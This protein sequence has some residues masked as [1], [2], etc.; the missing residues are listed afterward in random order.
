MSGFVLDASALIAFLTGEKG[1]DVVAAH[2]R[3]AAIS[4]V[5]ISEVADHHFVRGWS[6]EDIEALLDALPILQLDL[7]RETALDAASFRQLGRKKGLSQAD[8]LCLAFARQREAV[9]LTADRDWKDVAEALGVEVR[10]IR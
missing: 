7:D 9:A 3:G 6:R 10:F 1:K 2:L 5:H 8:C 4:A